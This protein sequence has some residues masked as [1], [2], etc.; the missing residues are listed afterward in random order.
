MAIAVKIFS[1][2]ISIGV[3]EVSTKPGRSGLWFEEFTAYTEDRTADGSNHISIGFDGVSTEFKPPQYSYKTANLHAYASS[4]DTLNKAIALNNSNIDLEIDKLDGERAAALEVQ[5]SGTAMGYGHT[6]RAL[7]N[8]SV[9]ISKAENVWLLTQGTI[10]NNAR[11]QTP[12]GLDSITIDESRII[13]DDGETTLTISNFSETNLEYDPSPIA[14]HHMRNSFIDLEGGNDNVSIGLFGENDQLKFLFLGNNT[15]DGGS[16]CDLIFLGDYKESF[17]E[18]TTSGGDVLL[19]EKATGGTLLLKNF[20]Y[21]TYADDVEDGSYITQ[22]CAFGDPGSLNG[23]DDYEPT[24]EEIDEFNQFLEELGWDDL[25]IPSIEGSTDT[26]ADAEANEGNSSIDVQGEVGT[27]DCGQ[28]EFFDLVDMTRLAAYN[29]PLDMARDGTF[30]SLRKSAVDYINCINGEI[31]INEK[32]KVDDKYSITL[33]TTGNDKINGTK[34]DDII[35]S[36]LGKDK[37]KGK[38]GDDIIFGSKGDDTLDGGKGDDIL[39]GEVGADTYKISKGNDVF[40]YFDPYTD[41]FKGK[42]NGATL[43]VV[44]D[45]IMIQHRKGTILLAGNNDAEDLPAI[46]SL[47]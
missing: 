9:S 22:S 32:V 33:G 27:D 10:Y 28:G 4:G 25:E 29:F 7:M 14:N 45:G 5:I 1:V 37:I 40:M 43:E 26:N 31:L 24:Q 18:S 3:P 46:E 47:L 2:T 23:E 13:L 36:S 39:H 17:S 42:L 16:G 30:E 35:Y 44:N 8:S 20:E 21:I 15:I 41:K 6:T 34:L 38:K 19:T 11:K 12:R